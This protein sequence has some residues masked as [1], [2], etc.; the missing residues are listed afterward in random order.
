MMGL[1]AGIGV[2]TSPEAIGIDLEPV[3]KN[4]QIKA[5]TVGYYVLSAVLTGLVLNLLKKH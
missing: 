5:L 3:A 2:I 4:N 1:S